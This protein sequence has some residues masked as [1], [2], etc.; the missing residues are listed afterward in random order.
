MGNKRLDEWVH[1]KLSASERRILMTQWIGSAWT[2]FCFEY[3]E[4]I[5]A[6]FIKC[7]ITV[8]M[9]GSNDTS[10]NIRGLNDYGVPTWRSNKTLNTELAGDLESRSGSKSGLESGSESGSESECYTEG[11]LSNTGSVSESETASRLY[12][13][14]Y[15]T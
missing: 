13:T 6:S 8:P 5:K 15:C 4:T 2:A 12:S 3:Q 7:G 11:T 10:I 14:P 9:D 1:G